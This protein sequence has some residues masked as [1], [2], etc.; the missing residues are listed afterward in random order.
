VLSVSGGQAA[1]R[2]GPQRGWA[3]PTYVLNGDPLPDVQWADWAHDGRLLVA[4]THGELQ[5]RA[6][7]EVI[8]VVDLAPFE[9]DPQPPPTEATRW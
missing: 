3:A 9:P 6:G 2:S 1:F 5:V 8:C 7:T 4:T